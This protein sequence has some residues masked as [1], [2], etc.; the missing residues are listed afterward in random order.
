MID[1]L[2][3]FYPINKLVLTRIVLVSLAFK[4]LIFLGSSGEA[5]FCSPLF[6]ITGSFEICKSQNLFFSVAR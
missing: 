2:L 6:N 4:L 5:C 1:F 3:G